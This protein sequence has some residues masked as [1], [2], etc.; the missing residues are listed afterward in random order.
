MRAEETLEVR[1]ARHDATNDVLD[2]W[3]PKMVLRLANWLV[4]GSPAGVLTFFTLSFI[5]RGRVP[6]NNRLKYWAVIFVAIDHPNSSRNVMTSRAA[7]SFVGLATTSGEGVGVMN[8][9]F[10]VEMR[11]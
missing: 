8:D 2:K 3:H 7:L 1:T 10:I 4:V 9:S 5:D 6:M 11:S